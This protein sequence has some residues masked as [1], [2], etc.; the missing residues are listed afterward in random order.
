MA[1]LAR[2]RITAVLSEPAS[3]AKA[4]QM[5]LTRTEVRPDG[6]ELSESR[7]SRTP[8]NQVCR[9]HQ[10]QTLAHDLGRSPSK[11]LT[12]RARFRCSSALSRAC[13]LL[14]MGIPN[15]AVSPAWAP[16]AR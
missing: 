11:C 13:T 16:A 2:A 10:A 9:G 1:W 15:P 3:S 6:R 4:L 14:V 8:D 5:L 12:R 7:D